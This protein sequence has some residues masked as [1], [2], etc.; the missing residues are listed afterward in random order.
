[1][2]DLTTLGWDDHFAELF[3]P[4]AAEGLI[5]G[6]ISVQHRGAYDVLTE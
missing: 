3:A 5:P 1:M 6:R 4:Y 2:P